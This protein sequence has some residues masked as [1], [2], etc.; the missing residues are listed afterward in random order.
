MKPVRQ[1][2]F[3]LFYADGR[4]LN[5]GNCLVSCIASWLDLPVDEVPNVYT[6]YGLDPKGTPPEDQLW[7]EIMNVWLAEKFGLELTFVR[8]AEDLPEGYVIARGKSMRNKP[9]TCIYE[10]R[11]GVLVPFFDPHPTDQFLADFDYY[12]IIETIQ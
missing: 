8:D 5:Y 2:K 3:S 1:T 10:K 11:Q 7:S 12:I 4:R 9:H 6:F